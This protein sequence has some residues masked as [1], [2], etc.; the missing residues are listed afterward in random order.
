MSERWTH[1]YAY[2]IH[3]PAERIFAA[4][5]ESAE[6]EA[7]F[8]E[9]A[10]VEPREGGRYAFWGKHTLGTPSED[11]A[12]GR[13]E[14]LERDRRLVFTWTVQ[15][16]P[17][18]VTIDLAPEERSGSSEAT[19][20][21]PATRVAIRHQLE[22]LF[23]MPRPKEMID[24]WWRFCL[25]NL[26]AHAAEHGDVLRVD[27]DDPSPEIRLTMEMDAPPEKV[28]RALTE[29][30]A[31]DRWMANG[32]EVELREGGRYDLG[33]TP[34]GYDGPPMRILEL[35]PNERL[36]ISWPDWRGDTSVPEQSVTWLLEP[37]GDGTRVT[38]IH[39]G[40]VRAVDLSDYP[41]GWGYFLGRLREVSTEL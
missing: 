34:E 4:L 13:I 21:G 41:F 35:V 22:G 14:S 11:E 10:R 38:V 1:E 31:L 30:E 3:A 39:S 2:P 24:D 28:F 15:G 25:G 9:H 8:A 16:V 6:L 17:S 7:W 33:F 37:S 18:T 27:F 26:M 23:D 20:Y 29:P 36:M 32:A 19:E 40:F 5:T 12:D